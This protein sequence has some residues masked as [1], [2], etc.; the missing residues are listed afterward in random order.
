MSKRVAFYTLGCRANQYDTEMMK[1]GIRGSVRFEIVD[2]SSEPDVYVINTCS[3]TN[4][5]DRKSRQYIRRATRSGGIVLVTGCYVTLDEE[6]VKKIDGVDIIFSNGYKRNFKYVLEKALDGYKGTLQDRD[7]LDWNI[8]A[9]RVSVDSAHSR[10]FLKVQ[11][12][13]SQ[14]CT[15]CKVRL[16]RGPTRSKSPDRVVDEAR[17]MA[18]NGFKE[19]VLIGINL[20]EYC[21]DKQALANLISRLDK[22]DEVKRIRLSSINPQGISRGLVDALAASDKTCPHLHIPL[23]SGSDRILERMARGYTVDYYMRKVALLKNNL[24]RVTFGTDV[25]VGFPGET[26]EDVRM[27]ERVLE[28]VRYINTHVFRYSP[29]AHTPAVK[30]EGRVNSAVKKERSASLRKLASSISLRKRKEFVGEK[31]EMILEEQSDRL[32]G[33][34]GYSKN[35]M[36]LHLEENGKR[37]DFSPGSL[38]EVSLKEVREDYCLVEL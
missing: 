18:D 19:L 5:A 30:L 35:Y 15:Y 17:R 22:L 13:C 20:A 12:G 1:E 16:L 29:R 21:G 31:M 33:W 38:L 3:V 32:H 28:E 7:L 36:D 37:G 14:R 11:D 6:E 27:T 8:D 23:Q 10:A 34:R 9:E 26:G 4:G 25:L 2:F 24:D